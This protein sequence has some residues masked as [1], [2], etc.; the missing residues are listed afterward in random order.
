M[1]FV[2]CLKYSHDNNGMQQKLSGF[3]AFYNHGEEKNNV[4]SL[5][6]ADD[7]NVSP[8]FLLKYCITLFF[9]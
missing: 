5:R 3:D 8:S 9:C 2:V 1:F 7:G 6:I 4:G